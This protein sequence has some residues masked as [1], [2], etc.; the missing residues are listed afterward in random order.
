MRAAARRQARCAK[1]A[2]TSSRPITTGKI[3]KRERAVQWQKS[4]SGMVSKMKAA[5]QNN[6]SPMEG[7]HTM[8]G[9]AFR[10][11]VVGQEKLAL[12]KSQVAVLK[13]V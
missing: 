12:N 6:Q 8:F 1:I 9:K 7:K 13:Q 4:V 5:E 10:A 3:S 2:S 11:P